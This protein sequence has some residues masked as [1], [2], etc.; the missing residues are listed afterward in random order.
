MKKG[1]LLFLFILMTLPILS[2]YEDGPYLSFRSKET[3]VVG[4]WESI[5]VIMNDV[6]LE[7]E[8][9]PRSIE[10]ADDGTYTDIKGDSVIG[11]FINHGTWQFSS[12]K[13][14]IDL[15]V[16]DEYTGLEYTIVWEIK[17]LAYKELRLL[18]YTQPNMTEWWLSRVE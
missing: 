17:K 10:F 1:P 18:N 11:L 15:M 3:R 4:K 2:C 6:E 12:N 8:G 5:K 13:R 9:G 16:R 14:A 7:N